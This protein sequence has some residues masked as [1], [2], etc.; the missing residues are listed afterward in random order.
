MTLE[1]FSQWKKQSTMLLRI[2]VGVLFVVHGAMKFG[3]VGAMGLAKTA[4]FFA[5]IGIPAPA[6]LAPLVAGLEVV[7][8]LMLVIGLLSRFAALWFAVEMAI[9]TLLHI[10][11]I[12]TN[13]VG[14]W[15]LD[16][17][18]LAASLVL[19]SHGTSWKLK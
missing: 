16:T 14:A 10:F 4:G 5:N 19:L 17:V 11:V 12:K 1:Y 7:G 13:Y 6:V 18:L 3:W 2:A 9:T 15:E 8:G